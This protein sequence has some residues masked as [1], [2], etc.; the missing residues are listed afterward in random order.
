[1]PATQATPQSPQLLPSTFSST[2]TLA[3][4]VRPIGQP[5]LPLMHASAPGQTVPQPPQLAG[6]LAT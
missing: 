5:Q 2:Q 4:F 3:Q 1:M 6:S